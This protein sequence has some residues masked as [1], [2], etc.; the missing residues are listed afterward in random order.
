MI[1]QAATFTNSIWLGFPSGASYTD[2]NGSA[3]DY[4]ILDFYPCMFISSIIDEITAQTGIKISGNL[5][6][7]GLFKTLMMPP[8]NGLITKTNL[9]NPIVLQGS[10]QVF[11]GAGTYTSFTEINDNE[12]AF[13]SGTFTAQKTCNL[14]ST[15]IIIAA[16]GA[17]NLTIYKNNVAL[18][19]S[20]LLSPSSVITYIPVLKG[21]QVQLRV[22]G[23]TTTTIN[24]TI[25]EYDKVAYN[26]YFD[27][28]HFLPNMKCVDLI[29]FLI[30]LF[31]CSS[32]FNDTT[33]TLNLNIIENLQKENAEDW[34]SYYL[35]HRSEYTVNTSKHNY[36]NWKSNNSD[37]IIANYN[38]VN[39]LGYGCGDIQTNNTLQDNQVAL[40]L[41]VSACS[42]GLTKN[43]SYI[44][45]VPILELQDTGE[46]VAFTSITYNATSGESAF[47]IASG[48]FIGA[49]WVRIIGS[50]GT[51]YGIYFISSS[52]VGSYSVYFPFYANDSGYWIKQQVKYN[53]IGPMVLANKTVNVWDLYPGYLN[54][55][56]F[57]GGLKSSHDYAIFT[58]F[59]TG[60]GALDQCKFN[61]SIDNPQITGFMDTTI[62]EQYLNKISNFFKNPP[63]RASMLLPEAIYQSYLFD[64]FVY[65]KSKKL[66]GYFF[67]D[68]IANYVDGN[69]PVEVNL[70]ML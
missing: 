9:F 18:S 65:I 43:N 13:S 8:G 56:S 37:Q 11:G 20:Y 68:N 19:P 61:L 63:I 21:D 33:N 17:V 5:L 60:L 38:L 50:N 24:W 52:G 1:N 64:K 12:N 57:E 66:I 46:P 41:P 69:T 48:T 42:F 6:Q 22:T 2:S 51:D 4:P 30:N 39:V 45:R 35:S 10:S 36:I 32:Y 47:A 44:T 3:F 27:P 40:P 26:S 29:K 59:R 14:K 54:W 16:T 49:E 23:A 62:K 67:V 70:Y 28:S 7:D 25:E 34:S 31:G 15:I 55:Y 58:K 53:N